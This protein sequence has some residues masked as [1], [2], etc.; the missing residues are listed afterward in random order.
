VQERLVLGVPCG[1][2]TPNHPAEYASLFRPTRAKPETYVA[3]EPLSAFISY[4]H[5]DESLRADLVSHMSLLKRQGLIT[6]WYDRMIVPGQ[7]GNKEIDSNLERA[8][9]VLFLVSADFIESL[10]CWEKEL[11]RSLD[12]HEAGQTVVIPI[13][14]RAVDLEGAPFQY[15]QSLPTD[16]KPVTSWSNKDEA[17]LDVVQGIRNAIKAINQKRQRAHEKHGALKFSDFVR[18]RTDEVLSLYESKMAFTGIPTGFA[19]LDDMLSGLHPSDL[20]IVA[21]RP[22]MGKSALAT[23]IAENVAIGH[24]IPVAVFSMEMPGVQMSMR[25]MSSLGRINAHR[26]RSGKLDDDDW[27]R[28]TAAV[29]LLNDAPIFIDDTPTMRIPDL[30]NRARQIKKEHGLGL[31]IVDYLQ[32]L[33]DPNSTDEDEQI[34]LVMR[35]LKSLARELELPVII[36]SQL[37]RA[38]EKKHNKRPVM[39]DV[40]GSGTIEQYAD[41]ILLMYRDEYYNPNSPTKGTAEII[42]AKQRSGPTGDIR[43]TFLGEYVRFEN[44]VALQREPT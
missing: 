7:D 21:A 19:D 6:D 43:L 31:I 25:M 11:T 1:E 16:R 41:V 9:I 3:Q 10:Y 44:Y 13:I 40:P 4:S 34:L 15:I 33:V 30:C 17:W 14:V 5:K 20:I 8:D 29:S 26:V 23:N 32:L 42:I 2:W 36:L 12:R 38:L 24:A 27:P 39:S 28:L 18:Q 35:S 37:N 22:G